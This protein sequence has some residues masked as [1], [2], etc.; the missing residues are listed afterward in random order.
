MTRKSLSN[1]GGEV[2]TRGDAEHAAALAD[3]L[4]APERG[5]VDAD[6]LTHGFHSYPGRM[7]PAIARHVIATYSSRDDVVVDPFAG[8]GTV[9]L[10]AMVAGRRPVGVDLN[11]LAVKLADV[12]CARRDA[13]ARKRFVETLEAVAVRSEER[14]RARVDSR[15]PL[16]REEAAWYEVHVLKELAGLR[17]EILSVDD[18]DDKRALLLVFSAILV[19]FSKQRADTSSREVEKRLRK[20][21]VTEFFVRKG[22]ELAEGWAEVARAA[23]KRVFAP[24]LYEGDA[25]EL[26]RILPKRVR[27]DLVLT[28][29]PYGGTYDYVAHHAR[30]FAW[31]GIDASALEALEVGAR[32][33]M[34]AEERARAWDRE[35]LDV[36]RA[37]AAARRS[38][39]TPIIV[40]MGDAQIG[41]RRVAADEQL[42]RLARD[43][44]LDLVASASQVRDDFRGGEAR[45]EHLLLL[46]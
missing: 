33:R 32:R 10:E 31:L 23:P 45:R 44:R 1:V 19:K 16:S 15:A 14:V 38:E 5:D 18:R 28:S 41:R 4:L 39:E 9:V 2:T 34:N 24:K 36:L 42:A 25:R 27:A 8:G 26:P 11:P 22:R 21:L 13:R 17:E 20:G 3:A 6:A 37:M 43:A 29:P 7:H 40:L 12:R 30:R 46:G 35:V